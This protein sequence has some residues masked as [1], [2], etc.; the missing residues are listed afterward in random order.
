MGD[1]RGW[2]EVKWTER[3]KD[4]RRDEMQ[5]STMGKRRGKEQDS[6]ER[7]RQMR[8]AKG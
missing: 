8:E 2:D 1:L 3:R 7:I 5:S 6:G 4:M